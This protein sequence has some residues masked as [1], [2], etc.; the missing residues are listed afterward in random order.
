[1]EVHE[2]VKQTKSGDNKAF[3][4]LYKLTEKEIWYTCISFLRDETTAQDVMQ[5]T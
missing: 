4:K 3:D 1:M 2:L 5:D